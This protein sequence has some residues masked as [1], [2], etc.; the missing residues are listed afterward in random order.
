L[1]YAASEP[2]LQFEWRGV[3][4]PEGR[5][6]RFRQET[7]Q[8]LEEDDRIFQRRR[9][10]VP[11]LKIFLNE[12]QGVDVETIWTDI[13]RLAPRSTENTQ[14]PNQKPLGLLE[15]LLHKGSHEDE[16]VLD[17]FC[18]S[19]TTIVAAERHR[20][21][22]IA[23]DTSNEAIEVAKR[24]LSQEFSQLGPTKFVIGDAGSLTQFTVKPSEFRRVAVAIEE[25][26][27]IGHSEFILNRPV[28]IEETR[29]FEFKEVR[30]TAGAVDSIVNASDN[31]AVAFLNGEGG[32]VYWGIRNED[33]VVVGVRLNYAER[34]KVRRDVTSKLNQIE[35]RVDPSRYRLEL[36]VS[37]R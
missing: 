4:L 7:L 14:Y 27:S 6:W 13:P 15:R 29:H 33:R 31:Y 11:N 19:G 21:Q 10:Q 3:V 34:D 12:D 17:P 23:C 26:F 16:V 32:R 35:P 24:R 9:G 20:R 37:H 1:T 25:M 2:S 18:G 30:S 28:L 5:S 36:H 22:W 8:Q